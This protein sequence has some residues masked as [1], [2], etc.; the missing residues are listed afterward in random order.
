M[1]HGEC[2]RAQASPNCV[3]AILVQIKRLIPLLRNFRT[4]NP[5][6]ACL[7]QKSTVP[8]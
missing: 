7:A 1:V 2:S 6:R 8:K 4:Q 5:D 3:A